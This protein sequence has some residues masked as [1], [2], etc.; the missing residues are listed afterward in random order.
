[1]SARTTLPLGIDV[2]AARTRVALAERDADETVR[3]IA[4]AT[5][6]TGTD[7]E[8]AIANAVAQLATR[9]RRCVLALGAPET[10]LR[11]V[12]FPQLSRRERERAARFEAARTIAYPVADAAVRLIALDA[13]RC[14]LA[15]APQRAIEQRI[16]LARAAGL[17]LVAIDDAALALLR[18][19]P[20]DTAILDVGSAASVLVVA[21]DPVPRAHVF[22]TGGATFTEA[23][24][25][26]LGLDAAAAERRKR[27][28]GLAGA[29]EFACDGFVAALTTALSS[30]RAEARTQIRRL[31]LCGNGSRLIGLASSLEAV[32]AMPVESL[33]LGAAV[34]TTIPPDVVR[35]AAPDWALAYG[36]AHWETAA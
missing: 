18:C 34:S 6:A 17:R 9:E 10:Q 22:P 36:L 14:V 19:V 31:A 1:M 23:I 33:D 2:G 12:A 35:A 16:A 26:A 20:D 8:H 5:A 11:V 4:V 3:L 7:P 15:I 13:E 21:D 28:I 30:A 25:R 27:T 24:G 32:L 29:G